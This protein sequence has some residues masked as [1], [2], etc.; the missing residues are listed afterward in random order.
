MPNNSGPSDFG[1]LGGLLNSQLEVIALSSIGILLVL[2]LALRLTSFEPSRRLASRLADKRWMTRDPHSEGSRTK[3]LRVAFGVIWIID[4]VL[5]LRPSMP[6]GLVTQVADPS[7]LGAPSWINDI[8]NPFLS[9]WNNHPVKLDIASGIIQLLIGVALLADIGPIS[10]RVVLYG[11]LLWDLIVF[12]VGNGGGVFYSGAAF[13]T[14]APAAI[15]VYAYVAILLLSADSSRS[16][17]A[18]V[19][20]TAY[21]V[22][23]FLA[24]GALL[25]ALP[26]EGYWH[27]GGL[28][29]YLTQMA[30]SVQPWLVAEPV[31]LYS[32]FASHSP[33]I[34]NAIMVIVP[35]SAAVTL[36]IRPTSKP[37]V[38]WGTIAALFGWWIGQ[39]MGV[40]SPT[41]TDFNSGFPLA[42]VI[43]SLIISAEPAAIRSR[44]LVEATERWSALKGAAGSLV[45]GIGWLTITAFFLSGVI[46]VASAAGAPSQSMA[47]VDS[48]GVQPLLTKHP[49]P[50]F[51]LYDSSG[52]AVSL[53]SFL[54][55][56]VVLTFLDPEC[57][58]AC[59]LIAQEMVSGDSMLG[60]SSSKVALVA[61]VANP[62]FHSAADVTAF[63]TSHGLNR[64][65]NWYYLTGSTTELEKVW[66]NYGIQVVVPKEGMV[67]H[68]QFLFFIDKKGNT[69]DILL[70]TANDQYAASYSTAIYQTLKQMV[71][72]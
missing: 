49:A 42:V 43:F 28:S 65:P 58:D 18:K 47:L 52:K 35:L 71:N 68:S 72:E 22:S 33:V 70:N 7:L 1:S 6:G 57:Y 30:S 11:S 51:T 3:F 46:L 69:K 32:S 60:K 39:D 50:S 61:I 4:G 56:P 37:V 14:G 17:V 29:S 23:A 45:R 63:D 64:Y 48:G 41:G 36:S 27:K 34:A 31:K 13:A 44:Y 20:P 16:W 25:Q 53:T 2:Y 54:G 8:A 62:I 19:R 66:K 21:F 67:V 40:F 15:V 24:I 5:Q 26:S 9:L 59:P 55:R 12:I 38:L 10:R